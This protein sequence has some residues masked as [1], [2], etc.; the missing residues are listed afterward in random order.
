MSLRVLKPLILGNG[1]LMPRLGIGTYQ[2]REDLCKEIVHRA[3]TLGYRHI[4]TAQVYENEQDVGAGLHAVEKHKICRRNDLFVTTKLSNISLHPRDVRPSLQESL[5]K[6]KLRHVDLFLI[7]SPWGLANRGDGNLRPQLKNG[8]LEYARY[9]IVQTWN[10]MENLVK[11]GLTKSI[12]ISNFTQNQMEKIFVT[13]KTKPHNVQFECHAYYQQNVLRKFLGESGL[14]A[15]TAYSPLG[16][17]TRPE[18]H[19]IPE[20]KFE[21]LLGDRTVL[22]V[23][24]KYNVSSALVLLRFLLEQNMAVLVKTS[25]FDRLEDNLKVVDF[26]LD[27]EDMSKL[28]NLDRNVKFFVFTTFQNHPDFPKPGEPY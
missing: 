8:T 20:N 6:L 10:A 18:R 19:V 2:I 1:Y 16:A 28:K 27:H 13:A 15:I 3:V 12:G 22:E 4:D 26:T 21:I 7:H 23:A 5:E 11:E 25:N 17:P 9:D 14:N 24:Q